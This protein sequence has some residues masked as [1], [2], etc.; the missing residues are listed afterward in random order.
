MVGASFV[1]LLFIWLSFVAT[2]NCAD[3]VCGETSLLVLGIILASSD[4]ENLTVGVLA[5]TKSASIDATVLNC[6]VILM[7]SCL[8]TSNVSSLAATTPTGLLL[9]TL[10][11]R[12]LCNLKLRDQ[13]HFKNK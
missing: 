10:L 7:G 9:L 8:V 11:E 4:R 1:P 13:I 5:R 2:V 6:V 3:N 12:F